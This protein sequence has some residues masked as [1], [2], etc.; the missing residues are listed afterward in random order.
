MASLQKATSIAYSWL[1]QTNP[2]SEDRFRNNRSN[3]LQTN[4]SDNQWE[5]A[6]ILAHKCSISTKMWE[7]SYKLLTDW[8]ATPAKLHVWNAQ[9]PN[10]SWRC[11]NDTGT[12]IHIWWHCPHLAPFWRQVRDWIKQI[13]ETKVVLNAACCLLHITN[14]PLKRYK[15]S[16]TK[17]LLNAAKALIPLHWRTSRV[18]PISDWLTRVSEICEMEDT[19]AQAND[20]ID[21]FH[22]TWNR[23][24]WEADWKCSTFQEVY[25][26]TWQILKSVYSRNQ[27]WQGEHWVWL[28][29]QDIIS[30]HT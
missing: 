3:V 29:Q 10:T 21:R 22:K 25:S 26:Q 2:N 27:V 13:T 16:L 18:P 30:I 11:V 6:C 4:I 8:Y 14:F 9:T 12:L 28:K 17:H 15:N 24:L 20:R 23:G 5:K 1:Q 19:L 7:T